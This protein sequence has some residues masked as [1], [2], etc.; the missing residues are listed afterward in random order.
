MRHVEQMLDPLLHD[1]ICFHNNK[2]DNMFKNTRYWL[3]KIKWIA[4]Y[5]TAVEDG[6]L[7]YNKGPM[8]R[9]LWVPQSLQGIVI[10]DSHEVPMGGH[11]GV[12]KTV[13]RISLT[14]YWKGMRRDIE[15]WIRACERCGLHN[16]LPQNQTRSA[17][18]TGPT[19]IKAFERISMDVMGP[20]PQTED[21]NVYLF[22]ITDLATRW[23]E[24]IPIPNQTSGMLARVFIKN[25]CLRYGPPR[26]I[27]TD[28]GTPFLSELIQEVCTKL[29]IQHHI[30]SAYHPQTNGVA[31]RAHAVFQKGLA[32]FV[33][34]EHDDWDEV[35][36]YVLHAYLTT[37]HAITGYSPYYLVHG[38][39]C[40][41]F[42]D[43]ALIPSDSTPLR[44]REWT[45]FR[46][47]IIARLNVAKQAANFNTYQAQ[48]KLVDESKP[49]REFQTGDRVRIKNHV[50]SVHQGRVFKW[51]PLFL[52]PYVVEARRGPTEYVVVNE[53]N[54]M[55]RRFYNV[56]DIKAYR[57][58]ALRSH[59]FSNLCPAKYTPISMPE[60]HST[61]H[62]VLRVYDHKVVGGET[63]Y[64]IEFVGLGSAHRQWLPESF[65][66]CPDLIHD[67][68]NRVEGP[69]PEPLP[70]RNIFD[71][72]QPRKWTGPRTQLPDP[73]TVEVPKAPPVPVPRKDGLGTLIPRNWS[74]TAATPIG[75]DTAV[76][77]IGVHGGISEVRVNKLIS[78][79]K[80]RR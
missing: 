57:E 58:Y 41:T 73:I 19:N 53:N 37:P 67:Y 18:Y 14:Y 2:L 74:K 46:E 13:Q 79:F 38:Q 70:K 8:G 45:E 50:K 63:H 34:F 66:R 55:D 22:T 78:R 30:A 76:A 61:E 7:F 29:K 48:Q 31:E 59:L 71:G 25:F 56:D 32:K 28:R 47:E 52:G 26:T 42:L 23:C 20:F 4:N 3:N 33:N 39:E 80:R 21:G 69:Q 68:H 35:I 43:L 65:T 62:E 10:H 24:V 12:S 36:P 40:S 72:I 11:L 60:Y 27:L 44:T 5:E 51:R 17:Q 75:A 9:R 1:I 6:M 49:L 64:L 54:P 15:G 16:P 77:L